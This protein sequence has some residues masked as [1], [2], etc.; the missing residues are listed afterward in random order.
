MCSS[1]QAAEERGQGQGKEDGRAG[2]SVPKGMAPAWP[3]PATAC[4]AAAL[5]G[6]LLLLLLGEPLGSLG[7]R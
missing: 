6:V 5:L 1:Q 4:Q 2:D 3:W 7:S